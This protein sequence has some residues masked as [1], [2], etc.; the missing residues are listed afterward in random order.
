MN[1]LNQDIKQRHVMLCATKPARQY[2]FDPVLTYQRKHD[3]IHQFKE[4]REKALRIVGDRFNPWFSNNTAPS[5]R[6][7]HRSEPWSLQDGYGSYNLYGYSLIPPPFS[8]DHGKRQFRL[9]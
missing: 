1:N 3:H 8:Y 2:D 6:G 5:I 7:N 4:R 9:R